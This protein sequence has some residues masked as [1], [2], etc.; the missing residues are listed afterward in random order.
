M[1]TE[2]PEEDSLWCDGCEEII[3]IDEVEWYNDTPVC[4]HCDS[5]LEL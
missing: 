1:K 2:E 5:I 4:P 3:P